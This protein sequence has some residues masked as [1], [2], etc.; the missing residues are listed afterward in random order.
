LLFFRLIHN[1]NIALLLLRHSYLI[2]YHIFEE[3][4]YL[5]KLHEVIQADDALVRVF[6]SFPGIR[7]LHFV[8]VGFV[9]EQLD[10]GDLFLTS[11]DEDP[12][13]FD[14]LLT[15]SED[16]FNLIEI[17]LLDALK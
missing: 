17:V 5:E 11:L 13:R 9:I 16:L 8:L 15:V 2:D 12:A 10:L 6:F 1:F 3:L 7:M 4:T 14:H